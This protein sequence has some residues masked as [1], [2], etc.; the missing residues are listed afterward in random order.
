MEAAGWTGVLFLLKEAK[1]ADLLGQGE[2]NL[3]TFLLHSMLSAE[4]ILRSCVFPWHPY[5]GVCF[6]SFSPD[7][8]CCASCGLKLAF[9]TAQEI[10]TNEALIPDNKSVGAVC[11]RS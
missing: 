3:L 5:L 2:S 6:F 11:P 9:A 1:I 8:S 7:H 10:D 4:A